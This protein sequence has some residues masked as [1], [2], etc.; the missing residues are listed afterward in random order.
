MKTSQTFGLA[1]LALLTL[2]CSNTKLSGEIAPGVGAKYSDSLNDSKTKPNETKPTPT[3][4]SAESIT[5]DLPAAPAVTPVIVSGASLTCSL[6]DLTTASCLAT[7]AKGAAFDFAVARA[8]VIKGSPAVWTATKFNKIVT[9]EWNIDV[10]SISG[11]FAIGIQ[12]AQKETLT[13]W[14]IQPDAPPLNLVKDGGF[15]S[16][17]L[18]SNPTLDFQ[19]IMSQ[20]SLSWQA[21]FTPD[22]TTC[23]VP[24]IEIQ[25]ANHGMTPSEGSRYTELN[26]AC[27]DTSLDGPSPIALYQKVGNLIKNN[28]YEIRLQHRRRIDFP[29][30][31]GFQVAFGN[32]VLPAVPVAQVEWIEYRAIVKADSI[33]AVLS[34]EETSRHESGIGTLIDNVRIFDLGS[35]Q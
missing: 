25:I 17:I 20:P 32:Q 28:F 15:E 22:F 33:E 16:L 19:F 1:I 34:I 23:K 12:N 7:E 26:S 35:S 11:S 4:E 27:R 10:T 29:P 6:K 13:D 18:E 9:G 3:G 8:Y 31:V 30:P 24:Y 21:R 2:S 14:I 5:I